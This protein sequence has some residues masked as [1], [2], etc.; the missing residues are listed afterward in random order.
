MGYHGQPDGV[1]LAQ[2][3]NLGWQETVVIFVLALL[4]FGPKKLPQLGK[5]LGKAMSQFRRATSDLKSTWDR[6]MA[7]ADRE[8]GLSDTARE[9]DRQLTE[10]QVDH[11][12]YN[13]DHSANDAPGAGTGYDH[14]YGV[15]PLGQPVTASA[16][17]ETEHSTNGATATQGAESTAAEIH[18]L[19]EQAAQASA[20][21]GAMYGSGIENP[22]PHVE[23]TIARQKQGQP[24]PPAASDSPVEV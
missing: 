4:I 18:P 10:A 12:Y 17:L 1:Q 24:A 13:G 11:T 20:E 21:A 7:N 2:F 6:E 22:V 9:L 3:L 8:T 15:D 5:D 23:H 19:S 14:G 16:S